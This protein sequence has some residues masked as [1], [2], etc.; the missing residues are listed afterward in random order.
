[1]DL[2]GLHQLLV[3]QDLIVELYMVLVEQQPIQ[4]HKVQSG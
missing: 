1:V 3:V 4:E 2:N